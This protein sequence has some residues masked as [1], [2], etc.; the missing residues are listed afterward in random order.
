MPFKI[1]YVS[2]A[3]FTKNTL[4]SKF[5]FW[6]VV[7]MLCVGTFLSTALYFNMRNILFTEVKDKTHLLFAQVDS[8]QNYVRT[9]LRPSMYQ[10]LGTDRFV[11]E[12]MSSSLY[13]NRSWRT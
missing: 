6:L 12:S 11:L 13:P 8:I 1:G 7:S 2:M 9:I 10:L 4:Q 5:I 3:P